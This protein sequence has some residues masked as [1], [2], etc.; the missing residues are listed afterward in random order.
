MGTDGTDT[1]PAWGSSS[2][3]DPRGHLLS[4][5]GSS[6]GAS[7]WS[8]FLHLFSYL[9]HIPH[10]PLPT[11]HLGLWLFPLPS[12]LEENQGLKKRSKKLPRTSLADN[13]I[14]GWREGALPPRGAWAVQ[15][16][17]AWETRGVPAGRGH[18]PGVQCWRT[19][20]STVT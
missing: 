18:V 6:L 12:A 19:S 9:L 5:P 10:I 8:D 20:S 3:L 13:Q 17:G 15:P 11:L 2:L 7:G 1:A 16:D 4:P 14:E